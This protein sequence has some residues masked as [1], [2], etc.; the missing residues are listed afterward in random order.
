MQVFYWTKT[1]IDHKIK[2]ESGKICEING[3]NLSTVFGSR[4]CQLEVD[5]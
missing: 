3:R 1:P 5:L 2:Q 4:K